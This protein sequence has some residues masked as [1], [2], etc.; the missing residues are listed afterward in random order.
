[1]KD[2]VNI[3]WRDVWALVKTSAERRL[4]RALL[5]LYF[6]LALIGIAV[7]AVSIVVM[8]L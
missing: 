7:V 8:R 5:L 6:A 4:K 3:R 2:A 1:M